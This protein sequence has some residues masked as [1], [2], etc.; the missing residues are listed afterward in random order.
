MSFSRNHQVLEQ[1]VLLFFSHKMLYMALPSKQEN[2]TMNWFVCLIR[3]LSEYT[4]ILCCINLI[5]QICFCL[6][7]DFTRCTQIHD[8]DWRK[9]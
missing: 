9:S 2:R 7:I 4:C 8:G 6:S 3:C 5:I 1:F